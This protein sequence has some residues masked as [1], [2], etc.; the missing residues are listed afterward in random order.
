M[1]HQEW[2]IEEQ[3]YWERKRGTMGK[4]K[5][6]EP[7]SIVRRFLEWF[8]SPMCG[9]LVV[10]YTYRAILPPF[11]VGIEVTQVSLMSRAATLNEGCNET[12]GILLLFLWAFVDDARSSWAFAACQ[13]WASGWGMLNPNLCPPSP[14]PSSFSFLLALCL[15]WALGRYKLSPIIEWMNG[16][17][18]G[19]SGGKL[20]Q[21]ITV[22]NALSSQTGRSHTGNA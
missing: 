1:S 12:N 5:S 3:S 18:S 16:T 11:E 9:L 20:K 8:G 15:C 22:D 13:G 17:R 19:T 10:S 7:R 14:L 21:S 6:K 4:G 2:R